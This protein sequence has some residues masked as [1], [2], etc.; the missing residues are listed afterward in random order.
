[1]LEMLQDAMP[2]AVRS[3][4]RNA[5]TERDIKLAVASIAFRTWALA[6]IGSDQA[7]AGGVLALPRARSGRVHCGASCVHPLI[8]SRI[9]AAVSVSVSEFEFVFE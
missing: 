4:G 1:M 3:D 5:N 8:R 7:P 9:W 2:I 6:G